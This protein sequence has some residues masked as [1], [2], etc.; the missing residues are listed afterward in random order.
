MH[1]DARR[2]S[3]GR[4]P[5]VRLE[6]LGGGNNR[7][8]PFFQKAG[9]TEEDMDRET[10]SE[11]TPAVTNDSHS[12]VSERLSPATSSG[13]GKS[14]GTR[15]ETSELSVQRARKTTRKDTARVYLDVAEAISESH[16]LET[17]EVDTQYDATVTTLS[18]P[19]STVKEPDFSK[20]RADVPPLDGRLSAAIKW[21]AEKVPVELHEMINHLPLNYHYNPQMKHIFE[22]MMEENT[23]DDEPTSPRI[24]I[25]GGR[26]G[27]V[28]PPWEFY[29]TNKVLHGEGVPR[30][31]KRNLEG[32]SCIGPCDPK[33]KTCACVKRQMAWV[34]G[35]KSVKGF[36]YNKKG[37]LLDPSHPVFECNDA[38][39]CSEDCMNRVIQRGR[40]H[41]ISIIHTKTKGWGVF[42]D[43]KIPRGTYMGIYAGEM[44][45]ES[46]ANERGK[47]Y[48]EFG[49]TYLFDMDFYHLRKLDEDCQKRS[50]N[51]PLSQASPSGEKEARFS[52][53]YTIDAFHVGNFTRF[54]N[55]SCDPN[56]QITASYVNEPDL[57][58]PRLTIYTCRDVRQGEELTF[59]Y[60]GTQ[61]DDEEEE[62]DE[63]AEHGQVKVK[64]VKE[65][66]THKKQ[67]VHIPCLCGA[68]NCRGQMF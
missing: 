63:V 20:L 11:G 29:Y 36:L 14:A 18:K 40:R 32:C 2:D 16:R 15:S 42:A 60:F 8:Q 7:I 47:L 51:E 34:E 3:T 23:A 12:S 43:E 68:A 67:A 33:S 5:N 50:G 9:Y 30:S 1:L 66:S 53:T 65:T 24:E 6:L 22:A 48:D 35:D 27:P 39:E 45:L 61:D 38:C 10:L 44:V 62:A 37:K 56:C 64:L 25:Y 28:T 41:G 49:R 21:P 26:S 19:L 58:K 52:S 54:L 13:M 57:R 17:M 4:D 55:H 31:N 59:A 46:E